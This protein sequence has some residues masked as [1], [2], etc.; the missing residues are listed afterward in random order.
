MHSLYYF[1]MICRSYSF[2][3]FLKQVLKL[4]VKVYQQLPSPDFLSMCQRLMFLDEPE[5]VASILE[6]LLRSEN[7]DD[8]LLAFQIAFDLVENEHQAFLLKVRDQLP[9]AKKS[10]PSEPKQPES[11][12][13]DDVPVGNAVTT[14]EVQMTDATKADDSASCSNPQEA[15]YDER[16]TKMRGILSGE[17]CIQLTLQFLYSHNK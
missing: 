2:S 7:L 13:P 8:A 14:E 9:S 6:K 11:V 16:L 12:Q 4:L 5:G 17:T 3:L 1:I 15:V 10:Q